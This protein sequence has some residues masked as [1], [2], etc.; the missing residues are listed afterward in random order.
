MVTDQPQRMTETSAGPNIQSIEL[1]PDLGELARARAFVTQVAIE[2]GFS[3]G[4]QFDIAL[5]SSEAAANAIEHAAVKDRV[6][7]KTLLCADRL[8]V[9]VAGPGEFQTPDRPPKRDMR[10]LGLPLMAKL[11]D[12]L[13]LTSRPGGGTLVNVTFYRPGKAREDAEEPLLPTMVERAAA[14]AQLS[15]VLDLL[16]A[17][18]VTLRPDYH[19]TFANRFFEERFGESG[20]KRCYE[21]LFGLTEPCEPCES[22]KPLSTGQT[23]CWDWIGPDGRFYDIH[24]FPF[25]DIDGSPLILEVG[26]DVTEL[27]Q[28]TAALQAEHQRLFDIF[29]TLPEMICLLT[30][31]HHVAYAN[32]AFKDRFG[33]SDGRHCYEYVFGSSAPC[34]F[35]QA[36]RVLE[37]GDPVHWEHVMKD[38]RVIGVHNYPINDVSGFP[39]ILE[40]NVDITEQKRAEET[41]AEAAGY[42]R[43]L[44]EAAPDPLVTISAEGKI[45]DINEAT[46]KITGRTREELTGTDFSEYFT[47]PASA[48][49]GYQKAFAEGAVTDY[50]LTIRSRDGKLTDVLYNASVFRNQEGEVLGVFAAARDITALRELEVQRNISTRLQESLLHIP[51]Q[52]G[53]LRF[54]HIYRSATEAARVGGDFYD[55]FE[56]KGDKTA[57]LIG[58]VAGHGIEAARTATLVKDVVHAFIHQSPRPEEVLKWTNAL[59]LEKELQGFVTLFLG[60]LDT[61]T[62]ALH[63]SSAGHPHM[64]LRRASGEVEVLESASPP[65]GVFSELTWTPNEVSLRSGDLLLLYTDGVTEAR[66]DGTFFGEEGLARILGRK[67]VSAQRLPQ[68]IVDKVLA[69]SGGR[70][71]DDVAVLAVSVDTL[72]EEAGRSGRPAGA[73]ARGKPRPADGKRRPTNGKALT[74]KTSTGKAPTSEAAPAGESGRRARS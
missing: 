68:L 39:M 25:T 55:A 24:D 57:L 28:A 29:E 44:I 60:I 5:V 40:M 34:D 14:Q 10:G 47:D 38:G 61:K 66:S 50:P 37:T 27:K 72:S 64:F 32:R 23:H 12:C 16:P 67:R 58:D 59:A 17:Y 1:T 71:A 49:Q 4:R 6:T 3:S 2:G 56:V 53:P 69:F 43:S 13:V 18:I 35:C 70:L 45:T 15:R 73:T 26:L 7:V 52:L 21:Y 65:L 48:R 30:P 46:V 42:A 20:G 33:E 11:S 9:E 31:D 8:E 62:G 54:S 63:Y 51:S 74:G 22:Y 41:A 36:Y 19:V